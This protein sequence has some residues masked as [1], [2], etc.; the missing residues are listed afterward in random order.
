MNVTL[1]TAPTTGLLDLQE[2]KDHLRV[3]HAEDDALIQGMIDAVH[4]HYEGPGGTLG[5]TFLTQTWTG[6]LDVWPCYGK[7]IEIPLPPLVTIDEVRYVDPDGATQVLGSSNYQV[8][9]VGDQP[10]RLWPAFGVSWPSIRCQPDAIDIDFTAGYGG[11]EKLPENARAA[12][13]MMIADLYDNRGK[14]ADRAFFK[15]PTY[16]EM[17]A[18]LKVWTFF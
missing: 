9:R 1:K 12:F 11:P 4:R 16:E 5:R 10:A 14:V 13:L 2:V 15:N 8:Q 7:A 17:M 3:D 18:P 6:R